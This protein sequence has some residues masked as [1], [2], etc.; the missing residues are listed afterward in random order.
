MKQTK[1]IFQ[2]ITSITKNS[3]SSFVFVL[4]RASL[5]QDYGISWNVKIM[6]VFV[7]TITILLSLVFYDLIL[8]AHLE[9]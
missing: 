8:N 7:S 4:E 1:A 2:K 5:L 9:Y 6:L 3:S